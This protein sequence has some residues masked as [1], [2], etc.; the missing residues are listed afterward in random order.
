[1]IDELV[2]QHKKIYFFIDKIKTSESVENYLDELGKLLES[3]IRLE[4]R[5]LFKELQNI[6]NEK[7]LSK[8]ETELGVALSSCKI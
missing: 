8:L 3:H 4:E 7:E 2:E 1:L 6:L 5:E